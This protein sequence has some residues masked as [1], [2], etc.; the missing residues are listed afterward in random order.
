MTARSVENPGAVSVTGIMPTARARGLL[1]TDMTTKSG[2]MEPYMPDYSAVN[3]PEHYK[4]HPRAEC[5]EIAGEFNYNVG[6]AIAYLWRAGRKTEDPLEDLRKAIKHLEM[7][8]DRL[9]LSDQT[10]NGT[11]PVPSYEQDDRNSTYSQL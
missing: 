5:A 11:S 10:I 4:W 1:K 2:S 9:C 6:T 7:E 8:C 3:Q